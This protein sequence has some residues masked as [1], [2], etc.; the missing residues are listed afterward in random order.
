MNRQRYF[1][2]D[3]SILCPILYLDSPSDYMECLPDRG[4]ALLT[5]RWIHGDESAYV[6]MQRLKFQSR[7]EREHYRV[8][9]TVAITW[10][11]I[12]AALVFG[13][14]GYQILGR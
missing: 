1:T 8:I 4:E 3:P 13:A 6:D 12:M 14:V 11:V 9:R 10:S 7:Q 5:L 2:A